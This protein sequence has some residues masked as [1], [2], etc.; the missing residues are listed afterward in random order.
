[1]GIN[2]KQ[3]R[4]NI[5]L[6]DES[7]DSTGYII[8]GNNKA[9]VIDT[10]IGRDNVY[11]VVRGV[12]DKPIILVNTHGHPDHIYGNVYFDK[13]YMNEAD[14]GIAKEHMEHPEFVAECQKRQLS[15]PPFENIKEGDVI[16]LGG[17]T[18]E[19]YEIPGHTLGGILLLCREERILFTGDSIN[20]HLWMQLDECTS[21][22]KLVESL[23]RVMFLENDADVI[24]HGHARDYDDI[25]LMRALLEGA[26]D[27][28]AG[29]TENDTPYKWFA[30]ESMQH[31][32]VVDETKHFQQNDHVICYNKNN[33]E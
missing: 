6:M 11:E 25:S 24:Y 18:L 32:F 7:G 28:V 29:K 4:N 8:V 9:C 15:M 10:M 23:E 27:L 20:H 33:I 16:D 22:K 17:L 2:L 21:I 13:A 3:V 12:T 1:M 31:P 30:G 19:V 14:L 5:Y 26:K